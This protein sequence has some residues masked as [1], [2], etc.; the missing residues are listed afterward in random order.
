M[1]KLT[2]H[3]AN[4]EHS[5]ASISELRDALLNSYPGASYLGSPIVLVNRDEPAP[6]WGWVR[7]LLRMRTDWWAATGIAMQHAAK[8]GGDNARIALAD[9]L[10]TY[11]ESVVLLEWTAPIAAQFPDVHAGLSGANF[12]DPDHRLATIITGQRALWDGQK[13]AAVEL[14]GLGAGGRD[15][16]VHVKHQGDLESLLSTSA[17]A[18]P[19]D[20]KGAWS[21][22]VNELIFHPAF[23]PWVP[24]AF[25]QLS[26]GSDAERRALLDWYG[27]QH[28]LWRHVELLD[29]WQAAPPAWWGQPAGDGRS[30]GD[31]AQVARGRAHAQA[32]ST[33]IADLAPIFGGRT[34]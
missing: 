24:S 18:G 12:G 23:Q 11:L 1:P 31:V 3:Y 25:A 27:E 14:D 16:A 2:F 6:A 13:D 26:T 22:L 29:R 4:S 33:P 28:D 7:D 5:F 34:A 15:L 20:G 32:A 17:A 21:W 9:F 19:R 8:D 10:D 30:L